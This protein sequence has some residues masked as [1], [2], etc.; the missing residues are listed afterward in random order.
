M[1][2]S[3][4]FVVLGL[5]LFE[6][7]SSI[8]NAI[9]N[10]E[11][12]T[13]MT[14]KW[15]KW[16][17]FWWILF[18]VFIVRWMLPWLIVWVSAPDLW[19]IWSL[20]ATFS[21]DPHVIEIIESSAPILLLWWWT[22][23]VFLFFHWLFLEHKNYWL[24][25]EK[26]FYKNW[27]WFFAIVSIILAIIVWK[28][29]HTNNHLLAF[30]AVIWSTAFFITHWFKENAEKAEQNLMKSWMSDISKIMYL[31]II[32]MTFSI[33]WVLWAF[34]FTLS[35]PLILIWNWIWAI[36]VRQITIW[37]IERIKKYKYLKNWAMYSI[38]FLWMFMLLNGFWVHIPELA[39]PIITFIV[40]WFFYIKSV[41]E[42]K[43][44]KNS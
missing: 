35:V 7:I 34:A 29:L 2:Y 3:I 27:V 19:F 16:F 12:L 31:E 23:L 39:S 18:A 17:L 6:V 36:V 15:R 20:T 25:W 41:K 38:L 40:I 21:N 8:D 22:F 37:N 30:W 13:T 9:I 32:D 26:F 5:C 24:K 4:I 14:P 33:D 42:I 11:V 28:A 43:E 1:D 44:E 10:A